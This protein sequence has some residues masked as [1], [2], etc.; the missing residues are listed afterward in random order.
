MRRKVIGIILIVLGVVWTVGV[1]FDMA[2]GAY[3]SW[4]SLLIG[5]G[6]VFIGWRLRHPRVGRSESKGS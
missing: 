2:V 4:L 6:L 3:G 1:I 5:V